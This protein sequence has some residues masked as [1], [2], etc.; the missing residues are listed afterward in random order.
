MD[1]DDTPTGSYVCVCRES[2][3]TEMALEE[4]AREVHGASGA[5]DIEQY[6]CPECHSVFGTFKE[7]REH[8][9]AHGDAPDRPGHAG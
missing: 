2:F 4:H 6:E 1:R 9:P 7:L 3:P 5:D 8:W